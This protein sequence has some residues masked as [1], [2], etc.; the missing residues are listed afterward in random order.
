[1]GG[2]A[3]PEQVQSAGKQR[4]TDPRRQGQ[5]QRAAPAAASA[6]PGPLEGVRRGPG[7]T[8]ARRQGHQQE[9]VPGLRLLGAGPHLGRKVLR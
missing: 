9:E 4:L 1:M 6:G 3:L 2:E 5:D 8:A 7:G